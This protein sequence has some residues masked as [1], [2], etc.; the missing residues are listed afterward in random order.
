MKRIF[1]L[2]IFSCTFLGI[3]Q[4]NAT[5]SE[6]Y[7]TETL[8]IHKISDHVYQH[9]SYLDTKSFGKVPCNGMIALDNNEAI[10]FDT[11]PTDETSGELID[12]I[13][14]TVK[15]KVIAIIPTHYHID[16][17]G[18]LNEF[19]RH[20]IPSY[21]YQ[22]TILITKENN[23]PIPQNSYENSLELK[24]GNE[25]I[26]VEFLGEGHTCD[27]VIGYFPAENIMFG[28]CLIKAQGADKG[29]LEE[30]SPDVWSETVEKVK[31]KYPNTRTVIPGHGETSGPELF[32]Y[33]IQLFK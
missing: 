31:S 30:A 32:D 33:T 22:R 4:I 21:A 20:G 18:G 14:N 7:K 9:I 10:I 8:I 27:N 24:V 16:N 6:I 11:P 28:G 5:G 15:H 25:K 29:N 1:Y 19:H 17:L 26:I 13:T 23:D 2:I 3:K 12:W